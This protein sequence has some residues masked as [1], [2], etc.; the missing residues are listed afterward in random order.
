MECAECVRDSR[1]QAVALL[2]QIN[3]L[4]QAQFQQRLH[5][6]FNSHEIAGPLAVA[7]MLRQMK[8]ICPE[9]EMWFWDGQISACEYAAKVSHRVQAGWKQYGLNSPYDVLE[10]R[11]PPQLARYK[12]EPVLKPL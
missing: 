6:L 9:T 11:P 3:K 1:R 7:W 5:Q 2:A 4:S 8:K 12:S 10:W